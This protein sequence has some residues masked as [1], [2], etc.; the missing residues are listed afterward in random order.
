MKFNSILGG[1]AFA[2]AAAASPLILKYGNITEE[3]HL[4]SR[5]GP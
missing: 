3:I 2:S 4:E 5:Q 1:I